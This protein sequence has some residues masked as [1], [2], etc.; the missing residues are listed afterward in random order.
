MTALTGAKTLLAGVMNRLRRLPWRSGIALGLVVGGGYLAS[1]YGHT[2]T[3]VLIDVNGVP[4]VH[5]TQ[6]RSGEDILQELEIDIEPWDLV[7]VPSD[8]AL[9]AGASI[10]LNIATPVHVLREGRITTVYMHDGDLIGALTANGIELAPW[11]EVWTPRGRIDP[12]QGLVVAAPERGASL[13]GLVNGLRSPQH[14]TIVRAVRLTVLDDGTPGSFL[15]TAD[16][17]G[18]ALQRE[19]VAV[20]EG[21]RI[22]PGLEWPVVAGLTVEIQRASPVSIDSDGKVRTLRTRATTVGELLDEVGISLEGEDRVS[23]QESTAIS[24]GMRVTVVRIYDEYFVEEVPIP[25]ETRWEANPE[26]EID[27]K[28]TANWGKEGA[29]RQQVRVH[30]ENGVEVARVEEEAWVAREPEDRIIEYGT[31]IVVRQLETPS[32]TLEYWRKIRML[33]TSY[34]AATAGTPVTSPTFGYTRLGE[35]AR[36]GVIAVDPTVISMRQAMY[37]PGYGVGFAGDTGAAIKNRRID[38]CFD[39]DNLESWYRWVDVYLLTPVPPASQ[40][41]WIIPNT[42]VERE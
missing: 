5:Y 2:Q 31:R 23:P 20:Y 17:V 36:K 12:Q 28:R 10:R 11:D 38:L 24:D 25:F 41:A 7:D 40:I 8:E 19:G 39:D 3:R 32:G 35:P 21:D 15:T 34:N 9:A 4:V 33:A 14:V 16:T 26:L 42:P 13:S 18:E 22:V 27:Q 37:V 30:Y 1:L 29:M 6:R